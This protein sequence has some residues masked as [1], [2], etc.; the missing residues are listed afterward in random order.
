MYDGHSRSDTTLL[1]SRQCDASACLMV[2]VAP[3]PA[4]QSALGS[5]VCL[6]FRVDHLRKPLL[7]QA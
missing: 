1:C 3:L 4:E 2:G 5:S 7:K 6:D